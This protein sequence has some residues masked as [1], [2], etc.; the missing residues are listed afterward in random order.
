[1]TTE[2]I[3]LLVIKAIYKGA[4]SMSCR[5]QIFHARGAYPI[6]STSRM[7]T[8]KVTQEEEAAKNNMKR[9]KNMSERNDSMK[10]KRSQ[11][12]PIISLV[13]DLKQS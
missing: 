13:Q 1:M 4:S 6:Q 2:G 7:E 9:V 11:T 12:R 8:V 3:V 10:K 5:E